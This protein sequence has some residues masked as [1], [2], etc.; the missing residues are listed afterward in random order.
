MISTPHGVQNPAYTQSGRQLTIYALFG[1]VTS[2]NKPHETST[3]RRNL[4]RRALIGAL[5]L[6]AAL[7]AGAA[8]APVAKANR[9]VIGEQIPAGANLRTRTERRI[10]RHQPVEVYKGTLG[11]TQRQQDPI[12][13]QWVTAYYQIDNPLVV[14]RG[15]PKAETPRDPLTSGDYAFGSV[16]DKMRQ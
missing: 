14:F 13:K 9:P 7:G 6:T 8:E 10:R 16:V 1:I 2:M 5:S 11:F 12:T 3:P 4:Q 15:N